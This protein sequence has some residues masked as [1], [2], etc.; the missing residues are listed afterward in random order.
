[1]TLA[2]FLA[3]F[4]SI[5]EWILGLNWIEQG[6]LGIFAALAMI[7]AGW[8]PVMSLYRWCLESYDGKII[9]LLQEAKRDGQLRNPGKMVAMLPAPLS[10]IAIAA[11]RGT[12]SAYKSLRR[13]ETRGRVKEVRGGWILVDATSSAV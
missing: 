12:N 2:D 8:K 13:L 6:V 3:R 11:K 4:K 7:G 5:W 9:H 10:E 1:M